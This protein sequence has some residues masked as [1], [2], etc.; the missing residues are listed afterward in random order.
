VSK[1]QG[2]LKRL[3]SKTSWRCVTP[4][5]TKPDVTKTHL[6]IF[7]QHHHSHS[8]ERSRARSRSRSCLR[9]SA[10]PHPRSRS[11]PRVHHRSHPPRRRSRSRSL[12]RSHSRSPA[13]YS[14]HQKGKKRA[15]DTRTPS[16]HVQTKRLTTAPYRNR[17]RP[18]FLAQRTK[19]PRGSP[20]DGDG[21]HPKEVSKETEN[22]DD[23]TYWRHVGKLFAIERT[24][25]LKSSEL[26][27]GCRFETLDAP[28]QTPA[29]EAIF[30]DLN[31]SNIKPEIRTTRKFQSQVAA[32]FHLQN[33]LM[34]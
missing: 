13:G 33:L 26:E 34:D 7:L 20:S 30:D 12:S 17:P 11:P 29:S 3:N 6:L 15:L 21:E 4:T 28:D 1:E 14:Y 22:K 19:E 2:G 8:P 24:P 31:Y 18:S 16:P 32:L 10:L 23:A 27:I 25:W 9:S 5:C